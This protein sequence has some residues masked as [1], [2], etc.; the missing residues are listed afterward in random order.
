MR[1]GGTVR[2]GANSSISR[3]DPLATS[4]YFQSPSLW[5]LIQASFLPSYTTPFYSCHPDFPHSLWQ[6]SICAPSII[7]AA[8]T[9][10][11]NP[12][13]LPELQLPTVIKGILRAGI[14]PLFSPLLPSHVPVSRSLIGKCILGDRGNRNLVQACKVVIGRK[15]IV[16][17]NG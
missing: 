17:R 15:K 5:F 14:Q 3:L 1:M 10:Q 16:G 9:L 8:S 2:K 13:S 12:L 11:Y 6:L 4:K 7:P